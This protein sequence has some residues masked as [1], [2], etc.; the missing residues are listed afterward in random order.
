MNKK[1][2]KGFTLIELLV[3]IS[4]ISLLSSIVLTALSDARAKSRDAQRIRSLTELRTALQMYANDNN[5]NY[6]DCAGG[7]AYCT[8]N[9]SG[10]AA[11]STIK[12][13]PQY[14]KVAPVDP[15]NTTN[16]YGYYYLRGC[17]PTAINH[18]TCVNGNTD[19]FVLATKLEKSS[20]TIV[21]DSGAG[22][23]GP[24][25]FLIGQ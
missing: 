4:I 14:I 22:I 6:P 7:N 2:T 16:Q 19:H 9:S 3:V 15:V 8:S 11:L 17:R 21:L 25:N 23:T 5:G 1:F 13:V 12:A 20:N 24:I 18:Y 10:G